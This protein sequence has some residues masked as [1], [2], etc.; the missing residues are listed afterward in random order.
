MP[1]TLKFLTSGAT[2]E[3]LRDVAA[4]YAT[5]TRNP[6]DVEAAGGVELVRRIREGEKADAVALSVDILEGLVKEGF[7]LAGSRI[8]LAKSGIAVAVRQGAPRPDIGEVEALKRAVLAAKSVGYSTGPSGRYLEKLFADWGIRDVI[9]PR[10]R[11]SPPGVPVGSFIARGEV[12]LGFQQLSE[13]IHLRGI[14]IVGPLPAGIQ[15]VTTFAAGTLKAGA[16]AEAAK[17]FVTY[18]ASTRAQE[19]RR[20]NGLDAP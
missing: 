1:Q 17:A 5:E 15:L 20:K 18:A 8:D 13:L 3:F 10:L 7:V 4:Q 9:A 14:D 12:E 2:K 11:Q 16:S 19:A 6:V